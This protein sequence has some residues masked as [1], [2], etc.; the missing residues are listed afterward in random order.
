M[1]V[2][3]IAVVVFVLFGIVATVTFAAKGEKGRV[4]TIVI[5]SE[6]MDE[7]N[8]IN[9]MLLNLRDRAQVTYFDV[10]EGITIANY[11]E[12]VKEVE[13]HDLLIEANQTLTIEPKQVMLGVGIKDGSRDAAL[14][15][16]RG[17]LTFKHIDD[18]LFINPP[19]SD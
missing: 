2:K 6:K 14:F 4:R 16:V 8:G 19:T 15:G 3:R 5:M 11:K 7:K 17:K 9:F 10:P 13:P 18:V 12:R 1:L